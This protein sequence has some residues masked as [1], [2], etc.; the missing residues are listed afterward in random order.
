MSKRGGHLETTLYRCPEDN[1]TDE[2]RDISRSYG[3]NKVI[4]AQA[5]DYEV[6]YPMN[7][8][9]LGSPSETILFA[10]YPNSSSIGEK[11][12][13]ETRY[14]VNDNEVGEFNSQIGGGRRFLHLFNYPDGIH[15]TP[16]NANY[17]LMDGSAQFMVIYDLSL[18][19]GKDLL[20]QNSETGTYFDVNK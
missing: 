14:R 7:I 19:T 15:G 8:E 17:G 20:T 5:Q 3:I 18:N 16:L 10:E 11:F 4:G 13:F 6:I 9:S 1:R 12:Q 2:T